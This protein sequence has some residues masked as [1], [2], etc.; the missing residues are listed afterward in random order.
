LILL[1]L[2]FL[3]YSSILEAASNNPTSSKNKTD[4]V[5]GVWLDVV[6]L[7]WLVQ[8]GTTLWSPRFYYLLLILPPWGAYRIYATMKGA[9]NPAGTNSGAP[10]KEEVSEEVLKRRQQRA[11]KRRQKRF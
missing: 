9:V 11:E 4:L 1:G 10:Q 7:V 3:C 2:N 8:A 6:A 5:G